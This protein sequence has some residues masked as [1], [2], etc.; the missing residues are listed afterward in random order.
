MKAQTRYFIALIGYS[1]YRKGDSQLDSVSLEWLV[2]RL[3]NFRGAVYVVDPWPD[4]VCG[5]VENVARH[6]RAV[7]V[8]VYWNV[9]AHAIMLKQHG[10]DGGRSLNYLCQ[11]LLD[12]CGHLVAFPLERH[13]RPYATK[14]QQAVRAACCTAHPALWE[15]FV[16]GPAP[17]GM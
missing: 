9:L 3:R 8:P 10:Q 15:A 7:G 16:V 5:L 6:V 4:H 2:F 11:Q 12:R 1:F 14:R 17:N 13:Q